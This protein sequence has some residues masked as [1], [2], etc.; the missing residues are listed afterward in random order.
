MDQA[1][2]AGVFALLGAAIGAL[3]A[4]VV[5]LRQDIRVG[6]AAERLLILDLQKAASEA[7]TRGVALIGQDEVNT[8]VRDP[9][10]EIRRLKNN[11]TRGS[12]D[13]GSAPRG[14]AS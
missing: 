6:R 11:Y 13:P 4:Y 9:G 7:E 8:I 5:A 1:I 10:G 2:L 14:R 12:V 3:G